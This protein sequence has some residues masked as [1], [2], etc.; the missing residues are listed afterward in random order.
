MKARRSKR[1]SKSG[2][3][4]EIH[5]NTPQ[6]A[7]LMNECWK[8]DLY[9]PETHV[10]QVKDALFEAGAGQIGNYSNCCWTTK[11]QGQFKAAPGSNPFIGSVN[12]MEYVD[13][14]KVEIVCALDKIEPVIAALKKAHPYE[15]PAFQYWKTFC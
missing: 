11:G 2:S 3:K 5:I 8:I 14:I 15:T 12:A 10:D 4:T 9:V 1:K 7:Y 6:G 13:E